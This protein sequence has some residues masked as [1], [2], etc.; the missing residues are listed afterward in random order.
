[1]NIP[2]SDLPRVVVIGAGFA[3]LQIARRIDTRYYQLVLLDRNNFHTFQ[4]LLYQVASASL[5]PDSIAY[6]IR[7]T[8]RD[9]KNT[10]YRLAEVQHIDMDHQVIHSNIGDVAYDK[11][12]VATGANNN[13]FGNDSIAYNAMPMKRLREALDLRHK[14]LSNFEKA[15]NTYDLREREKLMNFVIVGGGPTGVELAGAFAEL[16]NK[17]LPKDYPDLDL[18]N[19]Q[20]NL[21]EGADRLLLGMDEKSSEKAYKYLKKMDVKVYLETMVEKYEDNTIYTNTDLTLESDTVIW[22]AGVVGNLPEGFDQKSIAKGNRVVTDGYLQMQGKD[23]VYVLG[24]AGM[25]RSEEHPE[26]LPQLASVAMQQGI[27]LSKA[28]NRQA[29]GKNIEPFKYKDKGTMATIG[30]NLAVVELGPIKIQGMFAWFIWMLVHLMLLVGF[31]N[32]VIVF[33]NWAWNYIRFNSGLRLIIRP[34]RR[35]DENVEE[36]LYPENEE[37]LVV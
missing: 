31:R 23:H 36:K 15:L 10:F 3:G 16:K 11:L 21:L 18:R 27:Y 25:I 20:I 9:K 2:K 35:K 4:P 19:M 30:K 29:K 37:K 33:I 1:M 28:L 12:V 32:R 14:I 8:L 26:G 13:F 34:Y 5:E 6:P 24:D 7:K 17:V 22:A